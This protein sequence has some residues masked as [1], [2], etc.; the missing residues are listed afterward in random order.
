MVGIVIAASVIVIV[1]IIIWHCMAKK[2]EPARSPRLGPVSPPK[3]ESVDL[4]AAA[5]EDAAQRK[6]QE[7]AEAQRQEAARIKAEERKK[8]EEAAAAA[9][10]VVETPLPDLTD[11][12][13]M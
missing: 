10:K 7:E 11:E 3:P 8:Q 4:E 5:A 12:G 2:P 1:A 6:K 13:Q 9:Q